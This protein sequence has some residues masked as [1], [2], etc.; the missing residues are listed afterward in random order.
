MFV[1]TLTAGTA[2][3]ETQAVCASDVRFYL[4]LDVAGE[5]PAVAFGG[6]QPPLRVLRPVYRALLAAVRRDG[7]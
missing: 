5:D 7:G 2:I 1:L 3:F 6:L 4:A